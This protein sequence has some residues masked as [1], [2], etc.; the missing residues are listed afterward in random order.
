MGGTGWKNVRRIRTGLLPLLVICLLLSVLPVSAET[1]GLTVSLPETVKGYTPCEIVIRSPVAGEAE[2]KM[3]DPM[4]NLWLVR[5]G[6]DS[7]RE[8]TV[9]RGQIQH[10][11]NDADAGLR[12]AV[13]GNPVSGQK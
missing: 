13:F 11:R 3:F 12:A 5:K 1:N 6:Q 7:G 4:Q 8:R 2:L 9:Q 10:Q